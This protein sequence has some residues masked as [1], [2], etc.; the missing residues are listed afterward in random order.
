MADLEDFGTRNIPHVR[1]EKFQD[2]AGYVFP[3]RKQTSK[4][5]R[6][7]YA[8]HADALLTQLAE[9]LGPVPPADADARLSLPGLKPGVLVEIETK[10]PKL[11]TSGPA[12]IPTNLQFTA[13]DIVV[14]KSERRER[15]ESAV[16]FVPDDARAFLASRLENYGK[17]PGNE[18][19]PDIDKFEPL[20]TLVRTDAAALFTPLLQH[21]ILDPVWWELWV[22]EAPGRA[23]LVAAAARKDGLDVHPDRLQFPDTIV[24]HV[25]S[26]SRALI[27][28]VSRAPGAFVEVRRATDT[29]QVFLQEGRDAGLG[30]ADHVAELLARVTPPPPGAPV[31]C[32]L[33]SGVSAAHP[34]IAK[35][36]RGA[37]SFDEAWGTDDH[38]RH[39][40]HG[41]A[42]AGLVLYGD[43]FAAMADQRELR[44]T[45]SVESVK[46]LT[47]PGFPQ[48]TVPSYGAI[49]QGAVAI[50]EL[51]GVESA[52]T[53]CIASSTDLCS[54]MQPSSWSGALDQLAS[55][56]TLADL[57]TGEPPTKT[58]KRLIVVAAG[59]VQGG[60]RHEVLQQAAI[61][62]PAQSWN[63]LTVGGY[64]A[65]DTIEPFELGVRTLVK[66]NDVSPFSRGSN[67]IA[68]DLTPIKPEVLFE[69]GN[70][71]VDVGDNC[72]W[73]P[74]LSVLA[75]GSD[76][77]NEPLLPFWATSA[78]AGMA[79]NYLGRLKAELPG[80]WP[81]T[82]RA[83]TVHSAD[84]VGPM[85]ER[86]IG[87]GLHWKGAKKG[88]H[89]EV[90]REIGYGVPDLSRAVK[91][92]KNDMVLLAQAE[93]QPFSKAQ[94][95]A[96]ATYNEIHFYNL[97][98]P[99]SALEADVTPVS[100][101]AITR[102][103]G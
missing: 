43:L 70:M 81:E 2:V 93:I 14:L 76:V 17:D 42:L 82:Y 54:A 103:L 98:W 61:E 40:G 100:H 73:H 67:T 10:A 38:I 96:T 79:G 56:S 5:L 39:G 89:Q 13:E 88:P 7:D 37:W 28:F 11:D 99:K 21:E 71:A 9:A 74:S 66:A 8:A 24:L 55:G 18:R 77:A 97:P 72:D 85:R 63:A 23:D 75:A 4:P 64:T 44:L 49:T 87:R 22:R 48:P 95:G 15:T 62:D 58:A 3:K 69:A 84:W 78:A 6:D 52:R 86:L 59:N 16:V 26:P 46:Y 1:I 41:T 90:L 57:S 20:E 31:I 51:N 34:L 80:L 65:K 94:D 27:Q 53:F 30:P 25:L 32:V 36:M 35:G 12:K 50:A 91:S 29:I 102:V 47:P 19:R 83:L 101:P 60:Q 45:H 33:D 92:A 68:S